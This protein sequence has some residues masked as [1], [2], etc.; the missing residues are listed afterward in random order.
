MG[1]GAISAFTVQ[2]LISVLSVFE[3]AQARFINSNV[4]EIPRRSISHP[5][6]VI[7]PR[8][9]HITATLTIIPSLQ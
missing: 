2:V 1:T 5:H 4:S 7:R 3:K 6:L 9:T 8:T